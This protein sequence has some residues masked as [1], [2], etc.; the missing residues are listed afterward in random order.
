MPSTEQAYQSLAQQSQ[1]E[2]L[3]LAHLPLV[4]HIAG[5]LLAQ[6]PP[7]LD[8]ENLEAAGVL[9][10]VEAAAHF[11]VGR[12]TQFNTYAYP[13]IRGAILDE[14]RRNSPLPQHALE[15]VARVRRA[16]EELPAPVR[17]E[18]LV[19]A[20]GLT[21]EEVADSL[22]AIRLT[23]LLSWQEGREQA[24]TVLDRREQRPESR[25]EQEEERALL[26]AALAALA[27]RERLIVTLYYLEDLR[28]KEIG[29][30]LQLSESRVSRLLNTALF[31]LG[32]Y[33]RAGQR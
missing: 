22:A 25:L 28:L 21:A 10:L 30:L 7:G 33:V 6:L 9:G 17:V 24:I 11:D 15:N 26:S 14:L 12:G 18:D 27:E 23:S 2:Q 13:R 16:Y 19:R 8:V 31:H 32:E 5:K 4:R 29:R 20:T 3:I 1:R